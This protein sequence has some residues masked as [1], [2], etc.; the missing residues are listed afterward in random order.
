MSYDEIREELDGYNGKPLDYNYDLEK[1][2]DEFME[3]NDCQPT[4][5]EIFDF[6]IEWEEWNGI[7][8]YC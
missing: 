2:I 4:E 6:L 3:E 1:W 8:R 5:D 7:F